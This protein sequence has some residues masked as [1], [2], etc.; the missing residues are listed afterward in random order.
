MPFEDGQR[1]LTIWKRCFCIG[2]VIQAI[3]TSSFPSELWIAVGGAHVPV[4]LE[5][6]GPCLWSQGLGCSS[7]PTPESVTAHHLIY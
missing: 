4:V 7:N 3:L 5:V 1:L 6:K 2:C